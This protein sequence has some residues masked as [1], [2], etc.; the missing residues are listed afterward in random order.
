MNDDDQPLQYRPN[1][2]DPRKYDRPIPLIVMACVVVILF[3]AA[4]FAAR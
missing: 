3:I 2:Y 1:A 4:W